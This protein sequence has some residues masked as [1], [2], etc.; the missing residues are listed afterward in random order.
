MVNAQYDQM[1]IDLWS[2]VLKP[3]TWA[4]IC[5]NVFWFPPWTIFCFV[6]VLTT[7]MMSV[8]SLVFPP[9]AYFICVGSVMS[10]R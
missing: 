9:L 10:M 5:Y 3:Q 7:G 6:W 2:E 1:F 8:I 4:S